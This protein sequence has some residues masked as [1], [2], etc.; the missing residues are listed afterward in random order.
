MV[1]RCSLALPSPVFSHVVLCVMWSSVRTLCVNVNATG[2]SLYY[3][4]FNDMEIKAD[5]FAMFPQ[6]DL[7]VQHCA[8]RSH[9]LTWRN[10]TEKGQ[11]RTVNPQCESRAGTWLSS[12]GLRWHTTWSCCCWWRGGGLFFGQEGAGMKTAPAYICVIAQRVISGTRC[13][14]HSEC[15]SGIRH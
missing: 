14:I 9:P 8:S 6:V 12:P 13:G 10:P 2:S 7:I 5:F 15:P 4:A 11:D 3:P 1:L